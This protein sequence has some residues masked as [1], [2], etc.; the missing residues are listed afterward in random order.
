MATF[1]LWDVDAEV[2]SV[3]AFALR[4]NAMLILVAYVAGRLLLSYAYQ[5]DGI[6]RRDISPLI[7]Y[8]LIFS[9]ITARLAYVVQEM[10]QLLWTNPLQV[11][12]PVSLEPSFHFTSSVGLSIYGAAAGAIGACWISARKRGNNQAVLQVLDKISI[13][14][15]LTAFFLFSGSFMTSQSV[16]DVT[17]SSAGTVFIQPVTKGLMQIPCCIMRNPNG[18]NPLELVVAK[19]DHTVPAG[20]SI[21][22]N[23]ILYLFFKPGAT[24]Q[25]VNEFLIGDVKTFLFDMSRHIYEPGTE[26]LHYSIIVGRD[27]NYIGRVQTR[28][29]SR[30]PVHVIGALGSLC[31]FVFLFF[32][33]KRRRTAVESGKLF[34]YFLVLFWS[35]HFLLGQLKA[36]YSTLEMTLDIFFVLMGI[37]GSLFL[38]PKKFTMV[39][40]QGS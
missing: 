27:G 34:S 2:F 28:G 15:A 8:L 14:S 13:V 9:L 20:D 29:V 5:R 3:G 17:S 19:K 6:P 10:P 4:W 40:K 1:I 39:E 23:V 24:E 22:Q 37:I 36:E 38:F 12:F 31:L 18:K 35:M 30:I 21:H 25:L 26:P 16:G 32:L 7:A 33:W 11:I